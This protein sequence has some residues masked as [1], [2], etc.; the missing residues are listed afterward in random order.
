[1]SVITGQSGAPSGSEEELRRPSI[2]SVYPAQLVLLAERFGVD[3]EQLL[4]EAGIER[5]VLEQADGRISPASSIALTRRALELT[6]E[7][8]LGFY[9][10]LQLKL[11]SH[12]S[13]GMLAMSSATLGDAMQVLIRFV[14]LRAPNLRFV[15][16]DEGEHVALE[17][18]DTL[19]E[20]AQRAF[21]V[22]SL[23]TALM[24]MART[25]LG[26]PI[27][28]IVEL[29]FPEPPYF[30][31]FA[32][33]WP[34]PARFQQTRNRLLLPA[35]RMNDALQMADSVAA[36]QIEKECEQELARRTQPDSLLSELR[37]QVLAQ[38]DSFP[39]LEE[40]AKQ[41]HVSER[42]LKRQ[43]QA[44]G[45]TYRHFLDEI[46]RERAVV[47]LQNPQ[48]GAQQVGQA[49]GYADPANFH[50]AFRRWFGV[51]PDAWRK[52]RRG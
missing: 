6:G 25:L 10:G 29:A 40:I 28:G 46:K 32:H 3:T 47:L 17:L 4:R 45:T 2:P 18:V 33:L 22:E 27:A 14:S 16:Y 49:L 51:S 39:S 35:S 36:R 5:S 19:P 50:R 34:G 38:R 42:T 20:G 41:R 52:D 7:P 43:L 26:R 1:M 12:G 44:R 21:V 13:V 23:F 24:Q 15:H 48:L 30:P 31:R 9:Y 8:A 37:R 11:S